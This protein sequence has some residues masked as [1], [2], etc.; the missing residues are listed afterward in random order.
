MFV[1]DFA[2]KFAIEEFPGGLAVRWQLNRRLEGDLVAGVAK[3]TQAAD[4]D[5]LWLLYGF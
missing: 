2:F 5:L 4:F 1:D 3:P